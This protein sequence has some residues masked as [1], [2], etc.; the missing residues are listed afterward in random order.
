MSTCVVLG[1]CYVPVL[2]YGC[3]YY[4]RVM[5]TCVVLWSCYDHLCC[6]RAV[7]VV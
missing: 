4:G 3:V 5:S 6:L 1:P 2:Y 7:E